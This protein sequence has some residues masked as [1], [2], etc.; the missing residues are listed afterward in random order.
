MKDAFSE[1][2]HE[3][4]GELDAEKFATAMRGIV[5]VKLR[6]AELKSVFRL[7]D[8]D[9]SGTINL[10]KLEHFVRDGRNENIKSLVPTSARGGQPRLEGVIVTNV[11]EQEEQLLAQGLSIS[12][13]QSTQTIEAKQSTRSLRAPQASSDNQKI[14][15]TSGFRKKLEEA[16][17]ANQGG[18][19]WANLDLEKCNVE[20]AMEE[21]GRKQRLREFFSSDGQQV[22]DGDSRKLADKRTTDLMDEERTPTDNAFG[23]GYKSTLLAF[24]SSSPTRR[25]GTKVEGLL[26]QEAAQT[27]GD[28]EAALDVRRSNLAAEKLQQRTTNTQLLLD[29]TSAE[30]SFNGRDGGPMS[31]ERALLGTGRWENDPSAIA[32]RKQVEMELIAQR[33]RRVTNQQKLDVEQENEMALSNY[34]KIAHSEKRGEEEL[35]DAQKGNGSWIPSDAATFVTEVDV[36]LEKS[37]QTT[38]IDGKEIGE[39]ED[40]SQRLNIERDMYAKQMPSKLWRRQLTV[41]RLPKPPREWGGGYKPPVAPAQGWTT[42]YVTQPSTPFFNV[43]NEQSCGR[44]SRQQRCARMEE[45]KRGQKLQDRRQREIER[46]AAAR[47]ARQVMRPVSAARREQMRRAV[48]KEW[49]GQKNGKPNQRVRPQSAFPREGTHR[50]KKKIR[51]ASAA[52]V[53]TRR[54]PLSMNCFELQVECSADASKQD[55][56]TSQGWAPNALT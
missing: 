24:G 16:H 27:D 8:A 38:N 36:R 32:Q 43:D 30:F 56:G 22:K 37:M 55:I 9:Q 5:G 19:Q 17:V 44:A 25:N 1:W 15:A 11:R 41:V 20:I 52:P 48:K 10:H 35:V 3:G 23:D 46:R 12:F 39:N 33:D 28:H 13:L 51:P 47:A 26:Q 4:D 53:R 49:A 34:H 6:R 14:V 42:D 54:Q 29:P 45:K 21:E 2:D 31:N 50:K 40:L 18:L 7:I